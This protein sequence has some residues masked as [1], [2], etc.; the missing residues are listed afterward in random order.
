[1]IRGALRTVVHW[2]LSMTLSGK[3]R[4]AMKIRGPP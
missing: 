1:L 3:Y 2:W 4:A